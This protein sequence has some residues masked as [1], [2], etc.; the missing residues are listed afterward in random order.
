LYR[1]ANPWSTSD[2]K[3][4]DLI[5]NPEIRKLLKISRKVVISDMVLVPRFM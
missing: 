1:K 5:I 4:E 3:Y 2:E